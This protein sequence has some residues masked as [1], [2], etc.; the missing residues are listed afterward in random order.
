MTLLLDTANEV[1]V[2]GIVVVA[3]ERDMDMDGVLVRVI[4]GSDVVTCILGVIYSVG[5]GCPRRCV[6]YSRL[7]ALS[8]R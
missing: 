7:S 4:D 3:A 6:R 5:R 8:S 1:N 2:L